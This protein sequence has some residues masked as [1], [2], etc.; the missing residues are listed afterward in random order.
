MLRRKL[1]ALLLGPAIIVGVLAPTAAYA[2]SPTAGAAVCAVAGTVDVSPGVGSVPPGGAASGSYAF[3]QVALVCAGALAGIG[4][5]VSSGST[6]TACGGEAPTILG[7]F[8]GTYSSSGFASGAVNGNASCS[9]NV[10][11]PQLV[12]GTA[13]TAIAPGGQWS[14]TFGANIN[15]SITANCGPG[16]GLAPGTLDDAV[17]YF[18]AVAEPVPTSANLVGGTCP[19]P[20]AVAPAPGPVLWFCQIALEGVVV[21]ADVTP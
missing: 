18:A 14:L 1:L 19:A 8:C 9:G 7:S 20:P 6:G 16:G 12:F 15:G 2:G 4:S 21:L 3:H 5:T 17:G 11:G 10:G 13:P